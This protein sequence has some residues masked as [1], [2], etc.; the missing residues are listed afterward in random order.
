MRKTFGMTTK[1]K[2]TVAV[3]SGIDRQEPLVELTVEDWDYFQMT[4]REATRMG[5]ALL[6]A[7]ESAKAKAKAKTQTQTRAR[8]E[9]KA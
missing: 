6:K 1:D 5:N 9:G 4:P 3:F 7:A 8:K 2:D